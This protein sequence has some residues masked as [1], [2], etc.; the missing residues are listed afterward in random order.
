M[1]TSITRIAVSA[2]LALAAT[3]GAAA[4][5]SAQNRTIPLPPA[6]PGCYRFTNDEWI[7]AACDSDEYIASHIPHPEVEIGIGEI[8]G[9]DG[10]MPS[11]FSSSTVRVDQFQLGSEEDVNPVTGSPERGPNAYSIQTNIGFIGDNGVQDA[12]QFTD[13]AEPFSSLP[14]FSFMNN[15]CIWQINVATQKYS[16][17]CLSLALPEILTQVQGLN[18]GHGQLAT[19]A[20][21]D[22]DDPLLAVVATDKYDLATAERWTNV[23]GGLLGFGGGS[24]AHFAGTGGIARES[25]SAATCINEDPLAP[26]TFSGTQCSES[27]QLDSRAARIVS[28]SEATQWISTVETTNL[29]PVTKTPNVTFPNAWAAELRYAWTKDGKCPGDTKPPLCE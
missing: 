8:S 3:V 10:S 28:P 19:F 2:A 29:E 11:H 17:T 15:V 13:Q 26:Y 27:E 22:G 14:G 21:L 25:V 4:T 6:E 23:T 1:K 9:H 18:L 20:T 24:E 12:V 5:A 7:R 16:P